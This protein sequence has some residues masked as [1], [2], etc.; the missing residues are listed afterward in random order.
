[1]AADADPSRRTY[2]GPAFFSFGF[3]P[4]FLGGSIF[5][6]LSIVAWAYAYAIGAGMIGGRAALIWHIHEML[7]GFF[8]AIAV[9]FLLTAVPNWTGRLPVSGMR[10]AAL[11]GIW[12][13]GRVAMLMPA[14]LHGIAIVIDSAFLVVFAALVW[15]EILASGNTRN[16]PVC[17]LAALLAIA[18]ICFHLTASGSGAFEITEHAAL[19]VPALLIAVIGGRV[20]PSFTRNWLAA[21]GAEALPAPAG[22][23]DQLALGTAALALA[24]WVLAPDAPWTG[25]LLLIAG[26]LH[27]M[28]LLRWQGWQTGAEALVWILHV[29]Y[30]W[31]VLSF[32]L[33]GSAA[34]WPRH[35]PESAAIHALTAGAVGV[36]TL[37]IMT[38]S[39]L[40]HTGRAREADAWTAAIY[41]LVIAAALIRVGASL[42]TP[43]LYSTWI[44][45]SSVAWAGAFGLF[46]IRYGPML[47]R[48]RQSRRP[49]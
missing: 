18:N 47:V 3:R 23:F 46:A 20:V 27:F 43:E 8:A 37:G 45:A 28:R 12:L 14:E 9:G 35:V 25:V 39:T 7:F 42:F 11:F 48:P 33:M 41:L 16:I 6:A 17:G 40:G 31:L 30:A 29:G 34:L 24:A 32:L 19:A 49:D 36:M 26:T 15:R 2:S 22:R 1:M 10:L 44:T 38:R 21:R 4:F 13:A 5:A